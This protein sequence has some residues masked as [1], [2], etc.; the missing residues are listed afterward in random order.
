MDTKIAERI[1]QWKN[2]ARF[3]AETRATAA[4]IEQSEDESLRCFG[5]ELAFGTGGLRGI[6]GTGTNRMNVYTVA[7]A[8][9]GLADHLNKT[10]G[11][12]VA[13]AYDSRIGSSDFAKVAAGVLAKNGIIAHVYDRLMPTPML[14]FAVRQLHCDA[15]IVITASHNP[16]QYNGYKVY[17]ADGC[18]ITD[19]TADKILA[20]IS[21]ASYDTLDWLTAEEARKQG[22]YFDIPQKVFDDFITMALSRRVELTPDSDL[23]V[24]YTPLNGTGLDPVRKVFQAIG[25]GKVIEVEEQIKPDGNFP[26][27]PKPNPEIRETL[28]L[29]IERAKANNADLLIATDPDCDR[30]GVA[31]RDEKGEY[32]ILTGN[33][34][35]LLLMEYL[36]KNTKE[37]APVVIK[38]IVTSDLAFAIAK[39]YNAQIIEVLTGFKYIGE[40]IGRMESKG[41]EHRY[42]LGFEESCGYLAGAHVRDKDGVMASML[43]CDMAQHFK[44]AGLSLWQAR[45]ALYAKYG[46]MENRLINVEIE[47]AL[48]MERMRAILTALRQNPPATLAGTPITVVK[49]YLPG[50]EGL[51]SSDVLS[52][53]D[54]DGGKVI[55]RPSGTE[56]KVKMYLTARAGTLQEASARLDAMEKNVKNWVK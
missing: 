19:E 37:K 11:K 31:V 52:Y 45:A 28:T 18:Q 27:C 49:D 24:V 44:K 46:A 39:A 47:D 22:K 7:K 9:K 26:T 42:V 14:S 20:C 8:T 16:A 5:Q 10:G 36:L 40:T 54:K 53:Q 4:K 56:P 33:E 51:P 55:V 17:G 43:V 38:T 1:A 29:A 34:V 12:A 21:A 41:E 15:G 3:D 25:V 13:I 32:H 50:I 48:P 35:G 30:V 23:T 6:L 2:G